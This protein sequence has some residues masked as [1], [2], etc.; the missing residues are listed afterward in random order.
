MAAAGAVSRG[1]PADFAATWAAASTISGWLTEAQARVLWQTVTAAAPGSLVVEIGSHQGRSTAVLAAAAQLR[2]SRVVAIDP[3]VAGAKF[4]GAKTREK[5]ERHLT[6]LGLR[7]RVELMTQRST[8]VRRTWTRPICV[9]Y[10]DG[11]HDYWTASDDLR[12]RAAVQPGG[13]V[14]VHDAFSSIGVT[15]ALLAHVLPSRDLRYL[16]RTG[17]LARFKKA[18]P[19]PHDR[20]RI[21]RQLAWFAR[22]VAVKIAF[23]F[24]RIFGHSAPDPY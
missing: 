4:G 1:H 21:L 3:F 9:L 6:A 19:T 5:F 24:R 18:P 22:N 10:I 15:L 11:K 17:S 8:R 23:R 16:G 12:W 7:E 2:D 14:L 13:A 20:I